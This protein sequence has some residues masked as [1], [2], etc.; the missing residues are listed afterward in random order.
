MIDTTKMNYAEI[1]EYLDSTFSPEVAAASMELFTRL[2]K[3]DAL[4]E[5]LASPAADWSDVEDLVSPLYIK[6]RNEAYAE[7]RKIVGVS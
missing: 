3:F 1:R 7:I 4:V 5:F 6:G 2:Q